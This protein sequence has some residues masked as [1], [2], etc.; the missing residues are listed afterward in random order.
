MKRCTRRLTSRLRIALIDHFQRQRAA[1][2]LLIRSG[3]ASDNPQFFA[4]TTSQ[5]SKLR[6]LLA[7]AVLA[8]ASATAATLN[9]PGDHQTIQAA[10]DAAEAGDVVLVSPGAYHE[11]ISLKPGVTLKSAGDDA[12]GKLGLKRAEETVIDGA[13]EG[14][15]GPGVEMAENSILDGFTVTGVGEYDDAS[16]KKHHATQGNQQLH[17]HIGVPGTAGVAVMGIERCLVTNNIVHHI[18]YTGIAIMGAEGK[19]V[20]PRILRNV[21]YRNMGGGIGS[22]KKS[23]AIIAENVCFENFYAGIGHDD[24][25]PLVID[26]VC[27]ANI[28]A[29]IGLSE[30][31]KAT[32]RGNKCYQN[33]RAG[34]GIRTGEETQPIVEDNDC[35]QNG[36]A[37]I[38]TDEHAAPIIRNNRC[39]ENALAG[40]GCQDGAQPK[41]IG[42]KCYRNKQAGIGSMGGARPLIVGNECY[43]NERVGIGQR[44]DAQTTLIDNYLHHN[45]AAGIGYDACESGSSTALNNRVIDNALVAVGIQSGWT[46]NLSGNEFSRKGGLPPIIMVFEGADATFTKNTIRG[47]GV[48]GIRVSGTVKAVENRFEAATLRKVGPPSFAI[49]A[50]EGAQVTMSR[51][52]VSAWRHAL[53]ATAAKV[54]ADNNTVSEFSRT[55]FVVNQPSAPANVFGNTAISND[56]DAQ[57]VLIDGEEGIVAGNQ[58]QPESKPEAQP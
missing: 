53:N 33:R 11:R 30:H 10:I 2:V 25:S 12:K 42:N 39:Y 38:G 7:S 23:T 48:A 57:V 51:N 32:V 3:S 50:L 24:A 29:G 20:S 36:M 55:A 16:W 47:E 34:I 46:V 44:G 6:L 40:I 14:A 13:V 27:Y 21:T 28:R 54:T 15:E 49:W 26:N 8:T 56:P 1:R 37:G 5:L 17:E 52:E 9:V 58:I 19:R 4:S 45:K 31:S 18:G 43:E 22:M 41:I 35:Y